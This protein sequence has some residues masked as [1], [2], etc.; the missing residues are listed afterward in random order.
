MQLT[1]LV[2]ISL[3]DSATAAFPGIKRT[4]FRNAINSTAG[5]PFAKHFF[6]FI[7]LPPC[8]NMSG[9]KISRNLFFGYDNQIRYTISSNFPYCQGK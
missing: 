7:I 4:M 1:V 5:S 8:N 3:D 2:A 6:M 9:E